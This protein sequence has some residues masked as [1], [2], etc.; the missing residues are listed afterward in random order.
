M[1]RVITL[2]D[3]LDLPDLLSVSKLSELT[4]AAVGSLAVLV[5]AAAANSGVSAGEFVNDI[6]WAVNTNPTYVPL[7]DLTTLWFNYTIYG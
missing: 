4:L 1:L 5:S 3:K 7:V 6:K 2:H